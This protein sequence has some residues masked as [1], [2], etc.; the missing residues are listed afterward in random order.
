LSEGNRCQ[1]KKL[2]KEGKQINVISVV[3]KSLVLLII[4][5]TKE[6]ITMRKINLLSKTWLCVTTIVMLSMLLVASPQYASAIVVDFDSLD[7]TGGPITGSPVTDYLASYGITASNL[8]PGGSL[9][10]ANVTSPDWS[11]LVPPSSPNIFTM[12][13]PNANGNSF[14]LNFANTV[15]NFSLTRSGYVGANSPNG[16]ILGDWSA[17]AYNASNVAIGNVGEGIISSYGDIPMQTFTLG[18]TGI[19]HITFSA[20]AH[21]YAGNQMP[22][23]DNLTFTPSVAPEPISSI[24]FITGGTLLAGRRFIRRKA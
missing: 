8:T 6:G 22:L 11:Y 16:N 17:T 13:G 3:L 14:T 21:G 12:W 18:Y 24:L 15:D 19:S 9:Y 2:K 23:M 1:P 4:K 5:Q 20:N 7:A 10:V